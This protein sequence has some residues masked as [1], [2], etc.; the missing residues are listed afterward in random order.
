LVLFGMQNRTFGPYLGASQCDAC[1]REPSIAE[2]NRMQLVLFGMQ[3]RTFGPYLAA[4]QG[5]SFQ[6]WGESSTERTALFAS[7]EPIG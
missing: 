7:L 4:I 1:P 5:S 3:N 6:Y 2:T